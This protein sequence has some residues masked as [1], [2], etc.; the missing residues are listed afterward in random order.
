MR[1][2]FHLS[3]R[4]LAGRVALV[5]LALPGGPAGAREPDNFIATSVL[6]SSSSRLR[7][8][9]TR[10]VSPTLSAG[11]RVGEQSQLRLDWGLPYTSLTPP[12]EP[13]WKSMGP[14]NLLAGLNTTFTAADLAFLRVGI[15][16]A[17]PLAF[18][19]RGREDR[20]VPAISEDANYTTASA[21]RGRTD[22]WL[23]ALDTTS[24]V[25]PVAVGLD[26]PG[27]RLEADAALGILLPVSRDAGGSRFVL[28]TGAEATLGLFFIEPGVRA[29]WVSS[30]REALGD[31]GTRD[32]EAQ[33]SIEPF[34]RL[35]LGGGF[36][37]AGARF[38]LD[39]PEGQRAPGGRG[40]ALDVS[41]GVGF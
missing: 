7:D 38:N 1:L 10:H 33:F 32:R 12:G 25:V 41:A 21:V 6:F 2:P 11:F 9:S 5:A 36:V 34:L 31:L 24:L 40:W 23:W 15:A 35:S 20:Q 39:G 29:W 16:V 28:Q 4:H 14:S 17:L 27:L 8:V 37:R 18:H 19:D 30:P 22:P 3:P 26:L 13:R